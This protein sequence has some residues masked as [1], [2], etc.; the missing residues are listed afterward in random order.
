MVTDLA[1]HLLG[2]NDVTPYE[3]QQ[4]RKTLEVMLRVI[5]VAGFSLF[6]VN[7][8]VGAWSIAVALLIMS[9]L[10]VPALVLN[11][12]GRYAQSAFLTMV[13]MFFV[14]AYNLYTSGGVRDSGVLAYPMII[15]IGGLFFGRRGIPFL[16]LASI[17]SLAV[18]AYLE[19]YE[20]IL[21]GAR[22]SAE[23]FCLTVMVLLLTSSALVWVIMRNTEINVAHIRHAETELRKTYDLTLSGWAKALEYR[24]RE[25]EGHSRRVVDL[26]V[27]LAAEM[28]YNGCDLDH[29]RRGALLHDIG[30][31]TVPDN[32]LLKP[33]P[34]NDEEKKIMERHTVHAKEMLEPISFLKDASL[35]SYCH[36]ERWD[37]Q[38][39]PRGLKGDDIPW[40]ARVFSVV[41]QWDALSSR[42]PYRDAWPRDKVIEFIRENSGKRFDPEVVE[43]FLRI[44]D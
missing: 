1:R 44:V 5:L 13:M 7:V 4:R 28:G 6:L 31:M 40:Q 32:V 15:V 42:R 38:G 30:K 33:G 12:R 27:R 20:H 19:F 36:H 18:L 11:S 37:G 43:V 41:D 24:D 29:M 23:G 3:I 9:V 21:P 17:G 14:A 26:S 25:T 34:L 35:I 22:E 39:Y 2:T 16:A 8:Y 10:C